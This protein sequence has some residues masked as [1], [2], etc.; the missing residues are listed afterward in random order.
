MQL[1]R[2]LASTALRAAA[3]AGRRVV[4]GLESRLGLT[5]AN[6]SHCAAHSRI[7]ARK[8]KGGVEGTP[9]MLRERV[10]RELHDVQFAAQLS[11]DGFPSEK[12]HE[13]C[14]REKTRYCRMGAIVVRLT[15]CVRVLDAVIVLPQQTAAPAWF[16][17]RSRRTS[18]QS[19]AKSVVGTRYFVSCKRRERTLTR[20]Q[21]KRE[22]ERREREERRF[23]REAEGNASS[24]RKRR[25]AT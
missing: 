2:A 25:E 3:A 24:E 18:A 10:E 9:A 20:V 5:V 14:N 22:R 12:H 21:P 8:G 15:L 17:L 7:A 16:G 23:T 6:A 4:T 13:Q 1:E 19:A 11:R